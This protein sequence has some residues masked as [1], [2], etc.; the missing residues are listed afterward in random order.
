MFP[1]D[2]HVGTAAPSLHSG[3]V[4]GCPAER[5]LAFT[6]DSSRTEVRSE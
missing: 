5:S 3:Q 6:S 1:N 2:D 4:L